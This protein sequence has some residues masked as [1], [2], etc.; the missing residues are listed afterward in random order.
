VLTKILLNL[1]TEWTVTGDFWC[2]QH[3]NVVVDGKMKAE[4]P[5]PRGFGASC[6]ADEKSGDQNAAPRRD[7]T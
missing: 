2:A 1:L 7:G 6:R 3:G 4:V 5:S